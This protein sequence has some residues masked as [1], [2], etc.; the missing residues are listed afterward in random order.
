MATTDPLLWRT[1]LANPAAT[2]GTATAIHFTF[3]DG[4]DF[5]SGS[6]FG[7]SQVAGSVNATLDV[8]LVGYEL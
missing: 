6:V 7:M 2:L 4:M 5:P 8:T 3:P 1:R